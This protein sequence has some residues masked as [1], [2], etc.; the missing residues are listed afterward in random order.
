MKIDFNFRLTFSKKE[1]SVSNPR[2]RTETR[3]QIDLKSSVNIV[4]T[5][6]GLTTWAYIY[7]V[8]EKIIG[9]VS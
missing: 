8:F 5:S 4:I 3:K 1:S 2:E 6:V 9:Y 7:G